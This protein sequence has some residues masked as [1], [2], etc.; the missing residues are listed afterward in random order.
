MESHN[1]PAASRPGSAINAGMT[2]GK[3]MKNRKNLLF[4][5]VFMSVLLLVVTCARPDDTM[6]PKKPAVIVK[7]EITSKPARKI[8][9][10]GDSM[11]T[12]D[13]AGLEVTAIYSDDS[14][15]II[16]LD[17][18][19]ITGFDT[20]EATEKQN[21]T[22]TYMDK[23]AEFAITVNP[24]VITGIKIVRQPA[25][26]VYLTGDTAADIDLAGLEVIAF[27]NNAVSSPVLVTVDD[28]TGFDSSGPGKKTL[29]VTY[30]SKTAAFTV[31]V[32]AVVLTAL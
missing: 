12:G 24:V 22:V 16:P 25:K 7:I 10:V 9:Y 14:Q 23:T 27:Y 30:Q 20:T 6:P 28:I 2:H 13:L 17:D 19:E 4:I 26:T 18:L 5:H 31:D 3:N 21:I 8:Y 15:K 29:T 32:S 1:R 11:T